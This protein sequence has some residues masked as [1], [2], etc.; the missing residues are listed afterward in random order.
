M[1]G[2]PGT[3]RGGPGGPGSQPRPPRHGFGG[4]PPRGP[5]KH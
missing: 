1:R 5:K 3:H 4:K 2:G